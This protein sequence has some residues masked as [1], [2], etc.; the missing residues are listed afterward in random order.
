MVLQSA[1]ADFQG[2]IK[3][4]LPSHPVLKL[5]REISIGNKQLH[6]TKPVEG[7]TVFTDGSGKTG[8]AAVTW[9]VNG[10]WHNIV[11]EQQGSLQIVELRVVTEVFH[12][13]TEPFNLVTDSAYVAGLV[14]QLEKAI[15]TQVDNEKL[16]NLLWFL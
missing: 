6:S 5:V 10:E 4:H 7:L 2:Q 1:L 13:F 16:F 3:Y 15:I 12:K 8:E 14:Q 11:T 9:F